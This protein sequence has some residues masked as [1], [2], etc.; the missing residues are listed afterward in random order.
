MYELRH[1]QSLAGLP[2]ASDQGYKT[3][4]ERASDTT[5][6]VFDI[7]FPWLKTDEATEEAR[8]HKSESDFANMWAQEFGDPSDPAVAERIWATAAALDPKLKRS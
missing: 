7:L 1:R 8:R 2:G 5:M 3:L 4:W 6:K